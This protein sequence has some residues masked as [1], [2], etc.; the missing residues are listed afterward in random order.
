MGSTLVETEAIKEVTKLAQK[1]YSEK[2]EIRRERIRKQT[3][4][5]NQKKR[6]GISDPL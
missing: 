5:M 1:F 2:K 3:V 6:R 4:E